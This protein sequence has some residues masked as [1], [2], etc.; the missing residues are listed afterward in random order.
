MNILVII[1]ITSVFLYFIYLLII[2]KVSSK[3]STTCKNNTDCPSDT[4]CVYN[5]EYKTN[6]C[7]NK[8]YCSIDNENL[9]KCDLTNPLS[10]DDACNNELKFK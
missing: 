8:K 6:I 10:C 9:T 1:G 4:K 7:T 3:L 5:D 2:P